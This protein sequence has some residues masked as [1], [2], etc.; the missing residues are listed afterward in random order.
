[1]LSDV[2]RWREAIIDSPLNIFLFVCF[3]FFSF[4]NVWNEK[5]Q[6]HEPRK[7]FH[8]ELCLVHG[9]SENDFSHGEKMSMNGLGTR[10]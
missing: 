9:Y 10:K 5:N 8:G 3:W 4:E 7:T 6:K 1:M 2:R